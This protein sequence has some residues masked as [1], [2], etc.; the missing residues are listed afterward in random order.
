MEKDTL[1]YAL[2]KCTYTVEQIGD[3]GDVGWERGEIR[4]V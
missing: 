4:K 3:L 1:A 2:D